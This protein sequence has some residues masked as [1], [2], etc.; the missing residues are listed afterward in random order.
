MEYNDLHYTAGPAKYAKGMRALH[1]PGIDGWK[2]TANLILDQIAP[3]ARY[4]HREH[5][6]I[7]SEATE[8]KL[9]RAIAEVLAKRQANERK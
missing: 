9:D 3:N 4:S 5:A 6:Y 2:S 7:V 8:R 1:I